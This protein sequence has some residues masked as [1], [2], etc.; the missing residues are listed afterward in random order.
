M[1]RGVA[2]DAHVG[3]GRDASSWLAES[4]NVQGYINVRLGYLIT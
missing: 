1:I 2:G 4:E 3:D